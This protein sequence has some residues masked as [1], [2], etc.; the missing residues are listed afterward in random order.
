M[1]ML[2]FDI[3]TFQNFLNLFTPLFWLPSTRPWA[4]QLLEKLKIYIYYI[5]VIILF[6]YYFVIIILF[7]KYFTTCYSMNLEFVTNGICFEYLYGFS[8]KLWKQE[9]GC[10]QFTVSHH[11]KLPNIGQ[12]NFTMNLNEFRDCNK[13]KDNLKY[14]KCD[15]SFSTHFKIQL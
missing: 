3:P 2:E 4:L 15:G 5:Q 14:Y 7:Y 12:I 11:A 6:H 13:L 8:M 10:A 1:L 9:C